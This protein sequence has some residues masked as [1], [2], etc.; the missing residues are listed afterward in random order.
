MSPRSVPHITQ[1]PGYDPTHRLI[2]PVHLVGNCLEPEFPDST[3]CW[4]D[5][6]L[7]PREG[8]FHLL[9]DP[10]INQAITKRLILSPQGDWL[11]AS[12]LPTTR[13]VCQTIIGPLVMSVRYPGWA[14]IDAERTAAVNAQNAEFNRLAL[15]RLTLHRSGLPT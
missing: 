9:F 13:L 4:F 12:N 3:Q 10:R 11:L 1:H 5:P 2:G 14:S 7:P 8:W 15:A 6:S